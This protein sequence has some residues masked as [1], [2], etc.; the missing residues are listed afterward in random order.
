MSYFAIT[1]NWQSW[2]EALEL[3]YSHLFN[4][5]STHWL[6]RGVK[7]MDERSQGHEGVRV[8]MSLD[9]INYITQDTSP[10]KG[11]SNWGL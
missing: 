7:K 2:Q 5:D 1:M 6:S 9:L 4:P 10:S 3:V 11:H 8:M